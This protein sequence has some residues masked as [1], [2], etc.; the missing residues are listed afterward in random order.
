MTLTKTE[1]RIL[2]LAPELFAVLVLLGFPRPWGIEDAREALEALGQLS[3]E[4]GQ[5]VMGF[6]RVLQKALGVDP[7]TDP[8]SGQACI[9]SPAVEAWPKF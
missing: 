2:L 5:S 9:S 8:G 6:G 3:A 4:T 1:R 7:L